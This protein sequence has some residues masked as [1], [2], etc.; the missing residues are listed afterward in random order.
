MSENLKQGFIVAVRSTWDTINQFARSH[1]SDQQLETGEE[2]TETAVV[3][4]M[5]SPAEGSSEATD[6]G[7]IV[8]KLEIC[9]NYIFGS[10]LV[11]CPD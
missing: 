1:K 9:L 5:L 10:Y 8:L 11:E 2:E 7:K 6:L 4:P 3:K